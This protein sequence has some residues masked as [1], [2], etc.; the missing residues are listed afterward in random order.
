VKGVGVRPNSD[1]E[2]IDPLPDACLDALAR[3]LCNSEFAPTERDR[4]FLTY[5]VQE[6]LAGRGDRIKAYSVAVEVFG[7]DAS[8]D[9]QNDPIVRVQ[10]GHLRRA[11]DRYYQGPGHADPVVISIPKGG[12]NPVFVRKSGAVVS[13]SVSSSASVTSIS[14]NQP[15]QAVWF[16]RLALLVATVVV[17]TTALW[18]LT[19]PAMRVTGSAPDIPRLLIQ[20]L[21]NTSGAASSAALA[22]G[23]THE[24]VGQLAKFK[25]IMVVEPGLG[26]DIA[27]SSTNTHTTVT[28]R[29]ALAGAINLAGESFRLQVRLLDQRD[30]GVLWAN[31]Y[32][33][34][35]KAAELLQIESNLAG[36][37]ASA[38][39]QP[40]GIIF[41]ADSSRHF[42]KPP[43]DWDAYSC[44]LR[45]YAYR[46]SLDAATYPSVRKCLERAVERFPRYAT[47]WALLSQ[48]YVDEIRFGYR[49]DQS[50]PP[51]SIERALAAARRA[52]ELDPR[53]VRGLQAV[54]FSLYFNKEVEAALKIGEQALA[55]NPNDTE[56][57]GEYGYRLALSGDWDRG[58][59]FVERAHDRNPDPAAY[60]ESALALCAYMRGDYRSA[61]IWIRKTKAP[62][63]FGFHLIAAVIFAEAGEP[64]D[65]EAERRWLMENAASVAK[66][67]RTWIA[68][69]VAQS[70]DVD[71]FVA[72]LK[73]AGLPDS[74]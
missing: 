56:L 1:T 14:P 60:Y 73:K 16:L 74:E 26:S 44:T 29:Y 66:N 23:L 35:L 36:Q 57:M 61:S 54:M 24:I 41:Q 27:L 10:A 15:R 45:Y 28:A 46:A 39:A 43:D 13:E 63:N 3:I 12:Y 64:A 40:Y 55:M 18:F 49:L 21:E 62:A 50:S 7:R 70:Q 47:A 68:S 17:I 22:R 37:V 30:G 33:A 72:S 67:A 31:T 59:P 51:V 19:L 8:F 25:D 32:Y 58:C 65:A 38:L 2:D 9:P 69:R 53:N 52:V 20:P 48:T 42:E 6:A 71:R 4:K 34:D 11:L 5:V